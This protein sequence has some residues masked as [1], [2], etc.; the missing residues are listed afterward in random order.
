VYARNI[1]FCCIIVYDMLLL[2]LVAG[3]SSSLP[4]S[5]ADSGVSVSEPLEHSDDARDRRFSSGEKF[6]SANH[7]FSL[8]FDSFAANRW[9]FCHSFSQ[10]P[11]K[12]TWSAG[13]PACRTGDCGG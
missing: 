8:S 12:R 13:K 9:I 7:Q 11:V 2:L 5:P 1:S 6:H 4:P 3:L 10:L